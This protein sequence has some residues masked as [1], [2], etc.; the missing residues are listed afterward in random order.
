[1]SQKNRI[2]SAELDHLALQVAIVGNWPYHCFDNPTVQEFFHG[3]NPDWVIPTHQKISRKLLDLEYA[4]TQGGIT[5]IQQGCYGTAQSDG[6]KDVSKTH[7]I[8]FLVKAGGHVS[9]HYTSL[10]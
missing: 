10:Y 6:W 8:G 7:V 3:L 9:I 5:N 2:T 4:Q 1:M